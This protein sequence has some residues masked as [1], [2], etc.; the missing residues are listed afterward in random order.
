ME[1]VLHHY[2]SNAGS[3]SGVL[4]Q[5]SRQPFFTSIPNIFQSITFEVSKA[6]Q[7]ADSA[8]FSP[9]FKDTACNSGRC[10]AP[11]FAGPGFCFSLSLL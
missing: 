4:S 3:R 5:F 1:K 11:V 2:Y 10:H 6:L 9:I 8:F 7:H